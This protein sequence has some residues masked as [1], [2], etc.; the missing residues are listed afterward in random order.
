MNK[1]ILAAVVAIIM[2]FATMGFAGCIPSSTPSDTP[3]NPCG[4]EPC[5]CD[6]TTDTPTLADYKTAAVL[7]LQSFVMAL[8]EDDFSGENWTRILG[9]LESGVDAINAAVD[10]TGVRAARDAAKQNIDNV[11][12]NGG[13]SISML[14]YEV[15]KQIK[16]GA[17]IQLYPNFHETTID[18]ISF[19]YY[20]TFNGSIVVMIHNADMAYNRGLYMDFFDILYPRSNQFIQVWHN[21]SFYRLADAY[22]QGLLTT[23]NLMQIA[24]THILEND[25][26][27]SNNG[28]WH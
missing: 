7:Q 5:I 15:I 25:N 10:K 17:L 13:G 3:K 11:P 19:F 28:T 4:Q 24:E 2:L 20:G 6:T 26:I 18:E 1:K 8:E 14:T 12:Q 9:Y 21:G 22:K 16:Q 23:Q 27:Y